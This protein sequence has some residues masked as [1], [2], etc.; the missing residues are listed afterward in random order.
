MERDSEI[1]PS[2]SRGTRTRSPA[3]ATKCVNAKFIPGT[4]V[5]PIKAVCR[6]NHA[7]LRSDLTTNDA[8]YS[9][10]AQV[11]WRWTVNRARWGST[12][13]EGRCNSLVLNK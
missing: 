2:C 10:T 12:S 13:N 6:I 3:P 1:K 9:P 11:D 8:F 7:V 5:N 4:H